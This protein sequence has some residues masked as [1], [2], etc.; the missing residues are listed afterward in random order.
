MSQQDEPTGE[1]MTVAEA[2]VYL[3]VSKA[4]MSQL[5]RES[6]LDT[7]VDKFDKR[8][9]L[10]RRADVEQLAQSPRPRREKNGGP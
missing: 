6:V 10:I 9:K 5:I 7:V 4:K 8:I 3:D 1:Y 2:Q